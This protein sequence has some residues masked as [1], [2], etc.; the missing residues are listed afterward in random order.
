MINATVGDNMYHKS[1]DD[2]K[3]EYLIGPEYKSPDDIAAEF[4]KVIDNLIKKHTDLSESYIK[5][6]FVKRDTR[7]PEEIEAQRKA[8]LI[9]QI[10]RQEDHWKSYRTHKKLFFNILYLFTQKNIN[11][12]CDGTDTYLYFLNSAFPLAI[13]KYKLNYEDGTQEVRTFV[14]KVQKTVHT[15][16]INRS[17]TFW[18]NMPDWAWSIR[19]LMHGGRNNPNEVN[20]QHAWKDLALRNVRYYNAI[21]PS[22]KTRKTKLVLPEEKISVNVIT[23]NIDN[24]RNIVLTHLLNAKT[25][26]YN[27]VKDRSPTKEDSKKQLEDI[28]TAEKNYREE[29]EK[30]SDQE[31]LDLYRLSRYPKTLE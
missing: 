10:K 16:V 15:N 23:N 13:S 28:L 24:M 5:K 7:T 2:I 4:I 20:Y 26:P 11:Q 25:H 9:A 14:S 27:W 17:H 30:L 29:L 31:L 18:K 21:H 12:G 6:L 19:K 1:L 8:D 22:Y 3:K